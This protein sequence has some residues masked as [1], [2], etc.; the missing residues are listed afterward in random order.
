MD[1]WTDGWSGRRS[2]TKIYVVA[3]NERDAAAGL[4]IAETIA[5]ELC[6]GIVLAVPHLVPYGTTLDACG[7]DLEEIGK[8]FRDTAE[9]IEVPTEVR[10]CACREARHLFDR[11]LVDEA[12]VVIPGRRRRWLRTRSERLAQALMS[13]GHTVAFADT[14][15]PFERDVDPS[16]SLPRARLRLVSRSAG[17][18]PTWRTGK[19]PSSCSTERPWG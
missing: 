7:H 15:A 4:R 13:Q 2:S 11:I 14:A 1:F 12:V 5:R 17:A 19:T 6:R 8:R 3:E 10:V 16:A 9:M 18:S